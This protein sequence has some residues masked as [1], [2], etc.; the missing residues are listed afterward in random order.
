MIAVLG[1]QRG[2]PGPA[3][4]SQMTTVED[5]SASD[6][7]SYNEICGGSP[8]YPGLSASHRP[9]AVTVPGHEP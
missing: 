9:A 7:V 3:A 4:A 6:A 1:G 2:R 5:A 8:V